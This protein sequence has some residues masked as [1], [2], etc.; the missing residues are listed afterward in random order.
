MKNQPPCI[1]LFKMLPPFPK[2]NGEKIKL[3]NGSGSAIGELVCKHDKA[4]NLFGARIDILEEPVFDMRI[5]Q[6]LNHAWNSIGSVNVQ[7]LLLSETQI[8]SIKEC[9]YPD[10]RFT[11]H[12]N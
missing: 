12:L 3:T 8:D 5:D 6:P 4:K 10:Y 11:L 2:M 1:P 7:C 9:G